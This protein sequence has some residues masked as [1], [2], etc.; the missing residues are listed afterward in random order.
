MSLPKP[1]YLFFDGERL[2]QIKAHVAAGDEPWATAHAAMVANADKALEQPVVTVQG[3]GPHIYRTQSP[4]GGWQK[5]DASGPDTRDGQ[6]NP[7]A[8]RSDYY[9]A[10]AM[11]NAVRNLGLGW[12]F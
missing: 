10:I 5:V 2:D 7:Q 3:G 12:A 11:D 6:I 4:Y 8:D 1:D 9:A